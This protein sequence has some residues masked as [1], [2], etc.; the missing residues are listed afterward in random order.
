MLAGLRRQNTGPVLWSD[1]GALL[2]EGAAVVPDA[3]AHAEGVLQHLGVGG[4]GVR[5]LPLVRRR[6]AT[7]SPCHSS[8]C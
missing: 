5:R 1:I 3:V 6:P 7:T 4:A 2:H 8:E